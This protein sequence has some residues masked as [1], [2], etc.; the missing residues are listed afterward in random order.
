ML[1][2]VL[3]TVGTVIGIIVAFSLV[4]FWLS[5]SPPRY[6]GSETPADYDIP[7]KEITLRTDDGERLDGWFVESSKTKPTVIVGHGYPFDKSNILPVTKFL[8]PQ[9]NL[10]YFDFRGHGRSSGITTAGWRE[11]KDIAAAVRWLDNQKGLKRSYGGWG[12]SLGGA[13]LLRAAP[14]QPRIKA[15]ISDS[16]YAELDDMLAQLYRIFPGPLKLPF[17]WLTRFWA[18]VF[19]ELDTQSVSVAAEIAKTNTPVFIIHGTKDREIPIEQAYKLEKAI[20]RKEVWILEGAGHGWSYAQDPE[21]YERRIRK[22]FAK[23]LQ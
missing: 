13:A 11:T 9:Y 18:K 2:S 4:S 8:Y 6:R 19:F 1:K 20:K 14:E 5:V 22:F 21:E 23:H 10:L 3:F 7:Y 15:I 12:F 17:V 16:S